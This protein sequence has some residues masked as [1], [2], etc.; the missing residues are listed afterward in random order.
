MARCVG[1]DPVPLQWILK[2]LMEEK[3][4]RYVYLQFDSLVLLT[5]RVAKCNIREILEG[6]VLGK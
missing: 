2:E 1:V 4:E 3:E 6:Y 5:F